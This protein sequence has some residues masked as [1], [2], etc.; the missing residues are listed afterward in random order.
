MALWEHV[1]AGGQRAEQRH[2][3]VVRLYSDLQQQQ[4]VSDQSN[5][6]AVEPWMS[7]LLDQQLDQ[8]RTRL[9]EERRHREQV[10]DSSE[11]GEVY[12]R[13]IAVKVLML[14]CE[15]TPSKSP[16]FRS[17]LKHAAC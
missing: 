1:E 15:N 16:T 17:V 3:E 5:R 9:D 6:E 10:L 4:L 2:M 7:G 13:F 12:R 8:I 11:E 14:H